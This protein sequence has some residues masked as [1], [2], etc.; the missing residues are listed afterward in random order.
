MLKKISRSVQKIVEKCS[1]NSQ[2]IHL[3]DAPNSCSKYATMR[4]ENGWEILRKYSRNAHTM[5]RKSSAQEMPK[6]VQ[7]ILRKYT[8]N[9]H[10]N[11]RKRSENTRKMIRKSW[12]NVLKKCSRITQENGQEL[13]SKCSRN[14]KQMLYKKMLEN[15]Y[16][17]IRRT[18]RH[19]QNVHQMFR[20]YSQNA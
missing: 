9:A 4:S 13:Y 19:A 5:I 2:K 16:K 12:T 18:L 8:N 20:E 11:V 10:Q 6:N 15:V 14:S 17:I 3:K 1:I 7:E